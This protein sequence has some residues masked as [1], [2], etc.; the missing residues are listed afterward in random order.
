MKVLDTR[1]FKASFSNITKEKEEVV[2][3]KRGKP[4][5]IFQPITDRSLREK[6]ISI[7]MKLISLG[8]GRKGRVS[9]EH[10]RVLYEG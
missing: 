3:T 1:H 7:A 8:K 10:D 4:V 6:R 5:G 9:E 2:I